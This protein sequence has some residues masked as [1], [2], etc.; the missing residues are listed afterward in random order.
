M[1]HAPYAAVLFR[2]VYDVN[3]TNLYTSVVAALYWLL[4]ES[5]SKATVD[6]KYVAKLT[7]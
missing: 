5:I 3:D 6:G 2:D 1:Y 4:K 7:I